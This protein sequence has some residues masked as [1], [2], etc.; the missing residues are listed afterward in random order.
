MFTAEAQSALAHRRR[1]ARQV[2]DLRLQPCRVREVSDPIALGVHPAAARGGPPTGRDRL[3]D[4]VRRDRFDDVRRRIASGGFILIV[5]E[6]TAGKSRLAFEAMQAAVP[7]HIFFHARPTQDLQVLAARVAATR[8]CVVWCDEFD[9]FLRVGGLTADM[10]TTMLAGSRRHVT[11]IA[12]MRSKEYD[13]YSARQRDVTEAA[14]W[15]AGRDVLLMAQDPVELDRLW[16][17]REIRLARSSVDDLRIRAATEGASRFGVA[18]LLAAGPELVKDWKHAWQAGEHPRG[19]ALVAAAVDCRRMG[20]HRPVIEEVLLRLHEEYLD[21]RGGPLLR[22]ESPD[23]AFGWATSAVHGAS[24]LLLPASGGY[25]AFDYLIDLPWLPP[26]PENSWRVL[27]ATASPDEAFS[28]GWAAVHLMRTTIAV[29]AFD[30]ARRCGVPEA[31]YAHAIAL[32]NAG[33]PATAVQALWTLLEQRR[34]HL[35]DDHPA[36]LVARN[37]I[38]RYL[39]EAGE[40][41][42]ASGILDQLVLDRQR[43]LGAGHEQT[44]ATRRL[45]ARSCRESGDFAG[46]VQRYRALLPD[47]ERALG[48]EHMDVLLTRQELG[49]TL[50]LAG[51]VTEALEELERTRTDQERVIGPS[52]PQVLTTRHEIAVLTGQAGDPAEAIRQLEAILVDQERILGRHSRTLSTRHQLALFIGEAGDPGEAVLQLAHVIAEQ[53][54][55]HG[56]RHPRTLAT[57]YDHARMVGLSAGRA[58]ALPLLAALGEDCHSVLGDMHPLTIRVQEG[59]P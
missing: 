11:L 38:A 26:V 55:F 50:G 3:P 1:L 9:Q 52:H 57:R 28:I 31:E 4:F 47:Q 36:T 17:P 53:R 40:L 39:L 27:L 12:S 30:F 20:L 33:R 2:E 5:G 16:T 46:S 43:V 59:A 48:H 18:E 10:V 19:A 24:S 54:E 45:S 22:P 14:T 41:V 56:A 58:P 25:L 6:S 32:G 35:G 34:G 15:Q 29:E 8:N 44:L 42:R 51:R 49:R 13:R 23:A 7:G 21:A 37:D